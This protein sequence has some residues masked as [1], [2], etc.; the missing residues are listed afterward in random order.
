MNPTPASFHRTAPTT[1]RPGGQRPATIR[2]RA[3]LEVEALEERSVPT[4]SGVRPISEVGLDVIDNEEDHMPQLQELGWIEKINDP[5]YDSVLT[6]WAGV[7]P[8]YIVQDGL[9]VIY[10]GFEDL[11]MVVREVPGGGLTA[12][13]E[14]MTDLFNSSTIERLIGHYTTLLEGVLR[15]PLKRISEL[16]ILTDAERENQG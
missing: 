15:D 1:A 14:H 2:R 5:K 13:L 10:Q 8:A 11:S 12:G 4:V 9:G 7:D 6:N 3:R 16:S